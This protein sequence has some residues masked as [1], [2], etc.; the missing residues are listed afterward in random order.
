MRPA[1]LTLAFLAA[2]NGGGDAPS[3]PDDAVTLEWSQ[4]DEFHVATEYRAT[5]NKTEETA[6]NFDG[7][8]VIGD[9]HS[10]NWSGEVVWSFQAVESNFVPDA[11]DEL[12]EYA[13]NADG[14]IA[15]LTVLRA[16]VDSSLNDDPELLEA[17]PVVYLVFLAE[18]DRLAAIIS[19]GNIDGDRVEQAISMDELGTSYSALSQSMVTAAPTYLAPF[20]AGYRD[21]TKILENGSVMESY[22]RDTGVVDVTYDDEVGGGLVISTYE[23]GQPWPTYTEAD[24]V[25]SR[26]LSA[27]EVDA[28][29]GMFLPD[30]PEDYNFRD[31]LSATIKLDKALTLDEAT[32]AGG[33]EGGAP[34]GYRPWAGSW[35]RQ[36][37]GELIFSQHGGD[38]VST[39]LK[40]TV[41]PIKTDMDNL[42]NELRDI[43]DKSSTE[44]TTK[45]DEYQAKQKD[46]VDAIVTFYNGILSD[47]NGGNARV[48]DVG[49]TASFVHDAH[50]SEDPGH[51]TA[52]TVELDDLSPLDKYAL[53][54]WDKGNTSNNPWFA[55]GWEILNHYSPAGGSWWGH[56][57]GWAAAAI[58]TDEPRE[59]V[60][61]T[62]KGQTMTFTHGDQKG[63]ITEAHYSTY[64]NFYGARYNDEEDD[65]KDL[66]PKHFHQIIQFELRD[67]QV[68]LVFDTTAKAPVWNYPAYWADVRVEE[69]TQGFDAS[70]ININTA[71][72]AELD[73][74]PGIGEAY[75]GRIIQYRELNGPFQATSDIT[76]VSGIGEKTYDDLAALI[77]VQD[78]SNERTFEVVAA[79]KFST[80]GVDEEHMDPAGNEE[81]NGFTN[82]Y[83][84][85]LTTSADGVVIGDGVWE[86]DEEHPDFAWVPYSNPMGYPRN[87]S[88]N[89][90]LS[91]GNVVESLGSLDRK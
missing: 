75:A 14:T 46:L 54:E 13:V 53:V 86:D 11:A 65:I 87:G 16:Y 76:N 60:D 33:W 28:R 2:C 88:E 32:M 67:Q 23:D 21:E 77:I 43:D 12:F 84:Y 90:Y 68:P 78:A 48:E 59:T 30:P 37:A 15:E 6:V 20:S 5:S 80:D 44:Y 27:D 57:N 34:V 81:P 25:K 45:R 63:L 91:Y 85:T 3:L 39:H 31:A 35:W 83:R 73:S 17:D 70:L 69:T 72:L 36:S 4:G 50:G 89:G 1:L 62:V 56:C 49:G 82:T 42:S 19:F 26:L 29:R 22:T 41:D 61:V 10:D 58:L 38:T 47:L 8:T 66:T 64:S 18:R 71:T 24:D 40:S 7:T 79:V 74:L 51:D 55:P 9:T 52:W